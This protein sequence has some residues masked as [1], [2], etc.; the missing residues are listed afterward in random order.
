MCGSKAV[1]RSL[2]TGIG[3]LVLAAVL[4]V[5][6]GTAMAQCV[7]DCQ[8]DGEVSINDLILGVNI[9][10]NLQPADACS[11]FQNA[12]GEV[13]IAQLIK[14]VTNA[15]NGC[16]E[17]PTATATAASPEVATSTATPVAT[18][19]HTA[20]E[21][22][23]NTATPEATST[24][25]AI[26]GPTHTATH[27]WGV[28]TATATRTAASTSTVTR[29]SANTP[30]GTSASTATRTRTTTPTRTPTAAST[31]TTTTTSAATATATSVSTATVTHSRT[32][33]S[34]PTLTVTATPTLTDTPTITPTPTPV[35]VGEL[36]AGHAAIIARGLG[37]LQ[38]VVAAFVAQ[39]SKTP[40]PPPDLS[41]SLPLIVGG[42][43]PEMNQC[44]VA[45][46]S[47]RVCTEMGAGTSKSIHLMLDA[48][49]CVVAFAPGETQAF[50]GRIT[51]DSNPSGVGTCNPL[52]FVSGMYQVN[53]TDDPGGTVPLEIAARNAF[54]DFTV[55]SS[56]VL[57]GLIA[58]GMPPPASCLVGTLNLTALGGIDSLLGEF[59]SGFTVSVTFLD[60]N[61]AMD[62]IT[63]NADCVPLSY[64]FKFNGSVGFSLTEPAPALV[65]PAG[66]NEEIITNFEVDFT[67]FFVTQSIAT[68]SITTAMSGE[69]N[70]DC[71][72]P[73]VQVATIEPLVIGTDDVCPNAGKLSLTTFEGPAT[74]TYAGSQ[75]TVVQGGSQKV[76][77]SCLA[78]EL[79]TCIPQ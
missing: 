11:A 27:T 4:A 45:G 67:D 46:I 33:S 36:V 8:G 25:T 2:K 57:S 53:N 50:N 16:P 76:F 1:T 73:A 26:E 13:D 55:R 37:S 49:A 22:A 75:V 17:E 7:G 21:E 52:A 74:I 51:V 59:S 28:S 70:S 34:T 48:D 65:S 32:A 40:S 60:T 23:T 42:V 14:G 63:Y 47:Q 56:A 12:Q 3:L 15:L 71:F 6:G 38:S 44:S 62:M 64:R 58:I 69:M 29:T 61:V 78:D 9:A 43:V 10:L 5:H 41:S 20:P 77:P 72:G 30:T 18:A 66:I 68:G 79:T 19:T 39:A 31:V 54:M 35:P 24:H